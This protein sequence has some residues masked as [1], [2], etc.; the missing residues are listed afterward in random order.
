MAA[1]ALLCG[2]HFSE[3]TPD[4]KAAKALA[5]RVMGASA[6]SI[7]FYQTADTSD[8]FTLSSEGRRVRIGGNNANSMAV[9]LNHYLKY[10]CH[11]NVGWF[12][13]DKVTMPSKLPEVP[14]AVTI[15]ARVPDRFFLNYCTFGNTMPRWQWAE[16]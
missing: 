5:Q 10:Y 6:R 3:E 1:T 9:G 15:Q 2:C 12:S 11:V 13:W 8:V 16:W 7:E 14:E 4:V